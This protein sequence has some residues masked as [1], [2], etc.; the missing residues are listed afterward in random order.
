MHN[1][2][3]TPTAVVVTT[4]TTPVVGN[5][6]EIHIFEAATFTALVEE[7]K[8]GQAMTGFA[9][10]AGVVLKGQFT[11]YTLASGKVRAMS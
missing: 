3:N 4:N 6:Q 8:T 10:A 2:I 1:Q 9:I 7:N 5:F 11:G